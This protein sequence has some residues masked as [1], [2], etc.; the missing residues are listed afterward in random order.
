MM[1]WRSPP[2]QTNDSIRKKAND[3]CIR[4]NGAFVSNSHCLPAIPP[5]LDAQAA[6]SIMNTRLHGALVPTPFLPAVGGLFFACGI[7]DCTTHDECCYAE[8]TSMAILICLR[9]ETGPIADQ[10]EDIEKAGFALEQDKVFIVEGSYNLPAIDRSPLQR[11]VQQLRLGDVL[12]VTSLDPLGRN[13]SDV[14]ATLQKIETRQ[15]QCACVARSGQV[16]TTITH[17]TLLPTL[18]LAANFEQ[19]MR[20]AR[21]KTA[22]QLTTAQGR[23]VG[24]P[25]SLAPKAQ[26]EVLA[27]LR[28]GESISEVAR[29][30]ATSRQTIQRLQTA[31]GTETSNSDF[32]NDS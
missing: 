26:A 27:A 21:A 4:T 14:V 20:R 30:Y 6:F 5:R 3:G 8:Q 29:R 2:H 9:E 28:R 10:L 15:A 22:A 24:R 17:A 16:L 7:I 11:A 1:R 25:L 18:Q 13:L 31:A 23:R 32:A 12:V 19:H